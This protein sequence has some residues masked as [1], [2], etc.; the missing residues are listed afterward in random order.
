MCN[1][2]VN[3]NHCRW[4]YINVTLKIK[5]RITRVSFKLTFYLCLCAY[6]GRKTRFSYCLFHTLNH[7]TQV[8]IIFLHDVKVGVNVLSCV[9]Q[10]FS[11]QFLTS[12][13]LRPCRRHGVYTATIAALHIS[14]KNIVMQ[15][16][17]WPPIMTSLWH[18]L[19]RVD[20]QYYK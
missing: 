17:S 2:F 10:V 7:F 9:P 6:C 3:H 15:S 13:V 11:L 20:Q 14:Y 19:L 1:S 18:I 5:P 8:Y 4:S 16:N 12:W